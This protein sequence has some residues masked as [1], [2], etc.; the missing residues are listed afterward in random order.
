MLAAYKLKESTEEH[1][2]H[3]RLIH[4]GNTLGMAKLPKQNIAITNFRLRYV[5]Y[6]QVSPWEAEQKRCLFVPWI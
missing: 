6:F 3:R 4:L 1:A 2:A 5:D